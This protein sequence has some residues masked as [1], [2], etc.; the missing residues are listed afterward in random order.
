MKKHYLKI[1]DKRY[2]VEVNMNTAEQWE[3]LAGMR[4]GQ[5]EI[6]AAM[7]AKTGGVQTRAMLIW[8]YCALV[9]GEDIEGRQFPFTIPELKRMVKPSILSE[10]A[11][12]FISCYMNERSVVSEGEVKE[13]PENSQK[14]RGM[15]SVF[16]SLFSSL[17][18]LLVGVLL[19]FGL[20]GLLMYFQR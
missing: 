18:G 8:L 19:V 20:L 12:I 14:K 15:R 17:W 16:R 1:G 2:R 4:I 11:P 10:F 5:F 6:E 9:E 3:T 7:A 13:D